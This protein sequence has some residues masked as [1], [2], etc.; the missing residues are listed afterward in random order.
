MYNILLTSHSE[1][2][3]GLLQAAQMIL[4]DT[5]EVEYVV[6]DETGI[7]NFTKKLDEKISLLASDDKEL[8]ILVDIFG[9]TP[10]NQSMIRAQKQEN[11]RVV[12]GV[13]LAM[14]I[15][16]IMNK[17]KEIDEALNN[18]ISST[19]ESIVQGIICRE[20]LEANE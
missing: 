16:A 14:V 8:L 20:Q 2:C 13:N 15:E 10:F 7:D 9:G 12:S 19:K 18:I 5:D 3:I 17:N 4:G 6:L 11:I 1:L